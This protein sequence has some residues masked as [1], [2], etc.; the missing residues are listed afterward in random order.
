MST[1][2]GRGI[3]LLGMVR[4]LAARGICRPLYYVLQTPRTETY[5]R[6]TIAGQE[7]RRQK[8]P[9]QKALEGVADIYR[10]HATEPGDRLR[11]CALA[12]LAV[13]GFRV[14]ELLTLPLDCEVTEIS[15]G[16][17]RYGLRYY[18][19]KA[20]GAE[21]M[22]D[23]RWLTATGADLARKAI[24][25]IRA[26]TP[27]ARERAKILEQN[28]SRVPLPGYDWSDQMSPKEVA[29]ILGLKRDDKRL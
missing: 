5:S 4:F 21:K 29:K 15:G 17:T 3:Q 14:G 8:L 26:I 27:Q 9:S 16:K 2:Y 11:A 22:F 12:I 24:T 1:T 18:K 6:H 13:T 7:E 23:V 20:R 10:I 25:E 19:E 28:P